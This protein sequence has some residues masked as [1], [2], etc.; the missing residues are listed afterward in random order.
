MGYRTGNLLRWAQNI[1]KI[2]LELEG[3][4][5]E[6]RRWGSAS[7]NFGGARRVDPGTWGVKS[8]KVPLSVDPPDKDKPVTSCQ[9]DLG[10]LSTHLTLWI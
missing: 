2:H 4:R 3:G 7:H 8:T 5:P 6:G 1:P 9:V 10:S